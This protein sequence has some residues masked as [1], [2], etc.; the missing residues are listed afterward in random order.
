MHPQVQQLSMTIETNLK[1]VFNEI[2]TFSKVKMKK[3]GNNIPTPDFAQTWI[4]LITIKAKAVSFHEMTIRGEAKKLTCFCM[5]HCHYHLRLE[6][7]GGGEFI[8]LAFEFI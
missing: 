8:L 6:A 1:S 3:V 5:P 2:L 7:Q 4:S